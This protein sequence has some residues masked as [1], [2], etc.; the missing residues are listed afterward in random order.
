[1]IILN[2]LLYE[3]VSGGGSVN[4]PMSSSSLSE[5]F[6]MLRGVVSDFKAA[7]HNVIVL[8]DSRFAALDFPLDADRIIF[9]EGDVRTTLIEASK[10]AEAALIIAPETGMILSSMVKCV[11][12]T[13]L[14]SLNCDADIITEAIDKASLHK[15]M[16]SIGI[17]VP[18]TFL[19]S[20]K[21]SVH[22]VQVSRSIGFP[23][24]IK[25]VNGAGCRGIS[26]VKDEQE[27]MAS[28]DKIRTESPNTQIL[29]QKF[30]EGTSASVSLISTGKE[31]VAISL[32]KQLITLASPDGT[33]SY[34]GGETP[35]DHFL[36]AKAFEVS[37]RVIESFTG[38]KGYVGVDLILSKGEVFVIEVNARLTSS[39]TG[40]RTV[41]KI[42][43]A[44]AILDAIL[45][46]KLPEN[47]GYNGYSRFSKISIKEAIPYAY[48]RTYDVIEIASPPFPTGEDIVYSMVVS[49]GPTPELALKRFNQ[50]EN[51]I[52][53][54]CHEK[55]D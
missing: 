23:L 38:L 21:D 39:Y 12:S 48:A 33:S 20:A 46:G 7:G 41:I 25:P 34:N 43:I 6:A 49:D 11:E 10:D 51:K 14:L 54:I 16:S 50:A 29:V 42:N 1:V 26:I 37:K 55:I 52:Q 9:V 31:A 2:I 22:I 15:R 3:H 27:I 18:D 4:E 30:I 53:Q 24:V 5:G 47:I 35:L 28:V 32:N 44:E 19:C 40:L 45:K 8:L 13:G 36:K 17:C